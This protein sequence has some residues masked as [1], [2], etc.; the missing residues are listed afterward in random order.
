MVDA[1][2]WQRPHQITPVAAYF[3]TSPLPR[4]ND[5]P[6]NCLAPDSDI[7]YVSEFESAWL[8]QRFQTGRP[9]LPHA[10]FER[11]I[12]ELQKEACRVY[13]VQDRLVLRYRNVVVPDQ[14]RLP[15]R[16]E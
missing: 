3:G 6:S 4:A 10:G 8:G 7:K 5:T 2:R 9:Q 13:G 11:R 14:R 12:L 16:L 15:H 1:R